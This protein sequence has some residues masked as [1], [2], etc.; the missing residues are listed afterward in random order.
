MDHHWLARPQIGQYNAKHAFPDLRASAIIIDASH[1]FLLCAPLLFYFLPY[2]LQLAGKKGRCIYQM[3]PNRPL[4]LKLVTHLKLARVPKIRCRI[5]KA[6][7]NFDY[8]NGEI[9]A[10]GVPLSTIAD[11]YGSPTFVYSKAAITDAY[12]RFQEA[13]TG[14]RHRICYAVKAN[15]NLSVLALLDSLGASFDIV[16][17]GELARL[18][19][20]NVPGER[21]VFSGVGKQAYELKAALDANISCFNVESEQELYDLEK[22]AANNNQ[23]APVSLRVNPDVDA[24]THPYISTG[25]KENKFGVSIEKAKSLYQYAS[26]SKHLNVIGIDCHIGSQLLTIAPFMDAIERVLELV[27]ELS[28]I[29]IELEHLD[30]G[31]GMGVQYQADET[32]LD[33]GAYASAVLQ[34]T[35]GHPQELW[36]EPGRSI[37]ANSGIL[38]TQV[39]NLKNNEGKDF[40]VVDAAMNDLIRPALYQAWQNVRP[41]KE[42]AGPKKVYDVVGPVCETGDFLAK[43]RELSIEPGD[44]LCVDSSG[45]YGFVMSSNYNSRNRA[46][47]VMVDAGHHFLIRERESFDYQ[48]SLEKILSF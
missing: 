43:Q 15:S 46:A 11:T 32:A 8:L 14:K 16:S 23:N 10:E 37:V 20:I 13:F 22:I 40:C 7:K 42:S 48:F 47:E 4:P 44:L 41:V 3:K 45:A 12:N 24:N 31:G 27:N 34:Q 9:H 25:L 38:L 29:G 17:A 6:M 1:R 2:W 30:L 19:R 21:I 28:A 36:F 5:H 39:I 33:I 26:V 18:Q 35:S